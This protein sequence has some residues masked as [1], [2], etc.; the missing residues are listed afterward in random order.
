MSDNNSSGGGSRL[1]LRPKDGR[2]VAGVC[3][4]LAVY[5]KI[6]ANLVRL[7]FGILL[8]VWGLGALLYFIAWAIIPEED[9]EQSIVGAF[10]DKAKNR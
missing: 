1:I 4:A 6:D 7:G 8:F 10:I 3:A 9:E 5:F 2:M